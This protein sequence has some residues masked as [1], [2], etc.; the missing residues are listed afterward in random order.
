MAREDSGGARFAESGD[1]DSVDSLLREAV[2]I[3]EPSSIAPRIRLSAG[4]VLAGRFVIERLAG[5][6]G[7]GTIHRGTDLST[8]EAVAIKVMASERLGDANRFAQEAVVL[9]ELSHPSIVRYIAHGTTPQSTQFLA[10]EWLEGEDLA[11]RLARS[12]LTVEES[13]LLL[14]RACEGVAE[15]HARGVV[16]RDLK[17]SNLFL[18]HRDP[19]SL[20]VLDFGIARQREG[21]RTVTQSGTV[22]GTVGYMSPEQAM[23]SR[24]VDARTDVFALGCVLFECLTGRAAFVGPNAVAV[25]AK[26]LREDP[27]RV[28]ELRDG[29]GDPF[30]VLV[31]RMLAKSPDERP[32]DAATL[33]RA[34]D[35]LGQAAGG[36]PPAS[37]PHLGLSA[38]EQ[39]MV[40]VIL[41]RPRGDH[42]QPTEHIDGDMS[43]IQEVT[44]RFGAEPVAMRGGGLLVVLSGR[45]A[46]TDQASQAA[47]CVLL[48]ARLRPELCLAVA[49]GRAETTGR[50]PV[51]AAIDRAAELLAQSDDPREGVAIDELTAGLLDP[52]FEVRRDCRPLVLAKERADLETTRF[53]MGRPTPFVGRDKEIGLLDLTL[54][55]CIDES[56]ARAVL[57]TGPPGQG[58]SRLRHEFVARARERGDV[59]ILIARADPVGAGSAFLLVRR[60]VRHAMGLREGDLATEQQA[61]L[62]AYV[63]RV[64]KGADAARIADFLGELIGAPSSERPSPEL[65]AARNDPEMMGV[66]L[67]R[68]FGEWLSAECAATPLLLVLE[69]LHWGDLPSVTYLGEALRALAT[70]PL[71]V[72]ALARPEVH[73]AFPSLW[74]LAEKQ[75]IALGRLTP[76]AA[77]RLVR[78][79]L[80]EQL[81]AEALSR[82]VE[83]ADGN[84]FY[85]EEL[86]RRVAEGSS[87]SLPET[88]LALV[89]SRLERL[90]PEARRIVRAA[91]IF[92]E[93]FWRGGVAAVL[94][95]AANTRDLD[96]WLRTLVQVE[97]LSAAHESAVA[98]ESEYRF[99]HG[100]VREAAYAM[101]TD[102]DRTTGHRLAGDWL[103]QASEKDALTLANHFELGGER[104]RAIPWLLHAAHAAIEGGNLTHALSLAHRGVACGAQGV[105][106]GRLRL[107]EAMALLGMG[108]NRAESVDA[109]REAMALL[110]A[111]STEWFGSAV[112]LLHSGSSL[113]NP[114]IT[115]MAL[116]E[117][118][119]LRV[120]P[121]QS[122]PYGLAMFVAI[123]G[124]TRIGDIAAAHSILER[125]EA[126]GGGVFDADPV[127]VMWIR[128]A[129][130]RLALARG[131]LGHALASLSDAGLL[132]DCT[133]DWLGRVMARYHC[134]Q[135]S[136]QTGHVERAVEAA[137]EVLALC[138]PA[139][140]RLTIDWTT[141]FLAWTRIAADEPTE[142]IAPLRALL[143]K[144]DQALV[145]SARAALSEALLACGDM[146]EAE[147]EAVVPK[148][149]TLGPWD[150]ASALRSRALVEL[151]LG[152][153][154]SAV[155][156]AEQ[157]LEVEGTYP[158]AASS[159]RLTRAEALHE[160]GR[161]DEACA[162]I[163]EARDRIL[164]ISATL[165][166]L[167]LRASYL[168][169]V[170]VHART[171]T[172]ASEW[173]GEDT[174]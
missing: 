145:T 17:P 31:A 79:V 173:L 24:D 118:V 120:Q 100:L 140:L 44:R 151:R 97:L 65:R 40:S 132:A 133:G 14:R 147:R 121:E 54:R 106:R 18:M 20:K 75:E 168:T 128:I 162:A 88:V 62:R 47:R 87:E 117:V 104:V 108:W 23:G 12:P 83:Q 8:R 30:D 53:L 16:H 42:S 131:D 141:Y 36:A 25:L 158:L 102:A 103:E 112:A 164:Q 26:V 15:A 107:A 82:I 113:G 48:L 160:L 63:A 66:W 115:A 39:K 155:A 96:A 94:G 98:G 56:V 19:A 171:L 156:L 123:Q 21:T 142:A 22:L 169:R 152:R 149:G 77:E 6:G 124:L 144:A 58:K 2:A 114:S 67:R 52:S 10:M 37:R 127:F 101:L 165:D 109:T 130:A 55:E 9:A 174:Q 91:S 35:E 50:I 122:G 29:L 137:R 70:K 110:P 73:Q 3:S 99:R 146:D 61:S 51:G 43:R 64:C 163:R 159:L 59:R 57:V 105:E 150:R 78:E 89:Q 111:G 85:L 143:D 119:S 76:R 71:M 93:A 32:R 166:D 126:M 116:Q 74:S 11:E 157:G 49:T 27:P 92:G 80:G 167:E 81:A 161:A 5:S 60:L 136:S 46:A 154:R 139:G 138:E 86:I 13:L 90:E 170:Q 4:D 1:A 148:E 45:G 34:L 134:V 7:M 38:A 129:R 95:A 41:G 28:S 72:L 69:D 125:A 172:L 33:L 68:S 153:P 135:V 84:A